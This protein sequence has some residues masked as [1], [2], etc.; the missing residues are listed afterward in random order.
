MC[1]GEQRVQAVLDRAELRQQELVLRRLV[2]RP[3]HVSHGTLLFGGAT[4]NNYE[5][6]GEYDWSRRRWTA[7]HVSVCICIF[8]LL[9]I[10]ISEV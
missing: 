5:V 2:H 8:G 6:A 9:K 4:E 7:T 3:L 10:P 1:D